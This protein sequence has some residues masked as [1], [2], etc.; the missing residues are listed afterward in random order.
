MAKCHWLLFHH[1]QEQLDLLEANGDAPGMMVCPL[2]RTGTFPTHPLSVSTLM[3]VCNN[4]LETANLK[5]V[6]LTTLLGCLGNGAEPVG[7]RWL[8]APG[9]PPLVW[10]PWSCWH[11]WW[12]LAHPGLSTPRPHGVHTATHTFMSELKHYL[13]PFLSLGSHILGQE[14]GKARALLW[15]W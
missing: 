9:F 4:S 6:S 8:P 12:P 2:C 7:P 5:C 15:L 10:M 1:C 3:A 14:A 13:F 11:I